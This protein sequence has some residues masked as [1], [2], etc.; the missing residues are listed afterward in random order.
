MRTKP[1]RSSPRRSMPRGAPRS[2]RPRAD[3]VSTARNQTRSARHRDTE[4]AHL[5][6]AH[7]DVYG[8]AMAKRLGTRAWREGGAGDGAAAQGPGRRGLA[9][10]PAGCMHAGAQREAS[11]FDVRWAL[12]ALLGDAERADGGLGRL[13]QQ[14]AR[15]H[16]RARA[17]HPRAGDNVHARSIHGCRPTGPAEAGGDHAFDARRT[18]GTGRTGMSTNACAAGL[19]AR[20]FPENV[21]LARIAWPFLRARFSSEPSGHFAIRLCSGLLVRQDYPRVS[22]CQASEV[23]L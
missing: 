6:R 9:I 1:S 2:W 17:L 13:P 19:L 12:R 15:R 7:V 18:A 10:R 23:C 8:A 5:G 21:G 20:A 4:W 11:T 3:C 14:V 22:P 16:V